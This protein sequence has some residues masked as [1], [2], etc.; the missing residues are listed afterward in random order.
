MPGQSGAFDPGGELAHAG[1]YGQFAHFFQ[2]YD[3]VPAG[4]D[5]RMESVEDFMC[6]IGTLPLQGQTHQRS[7]GFG[8][9]T[10]RPF[11]TNVLDDLVVVQVEID[12]EVIAAEWVESFLEAVG[13]LQFPEVARV[14]VVVENDLLVKFSEVLH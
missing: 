13:T 11:K 3:F 2:V 14:L 5:Q 12:V 8:Y 6:V 9:C 4:G 10:A 7:R 1:K